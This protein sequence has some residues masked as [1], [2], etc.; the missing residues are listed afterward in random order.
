MISS[1]AKLP[2]QF[3]VGR[4]IAD[5]KFKAAGF[6]DVVHAIGVGCKRFGRDVKR[7]RRGMTDA[8]IFALFS[9]ASP[10]IKGSHEGASGDG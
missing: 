10:S 9:S 7:K 2:S 6:N 8:A 5:H 4:R 3:I 1:P